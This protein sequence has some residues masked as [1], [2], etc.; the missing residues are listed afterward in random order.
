MN[1]ETKK[2]ATI[3]RN[4]G[5]KLL[6]FAKDVDVTET[7]GVLWFG[8]TRN[9]FAGEMIRYSRPIGTADMGADYLKEQVLAFCDS[10]S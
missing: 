2:L 7:I 8:L 5:K 3:L 1:R 10:L 9:T 6:P 4:Y